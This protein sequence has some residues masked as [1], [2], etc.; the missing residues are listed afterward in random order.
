MM[1]DTNTL[2]TKIII[3]NKPQCTSF[4]QNKLNIKT[5][6]KNT[7]NV[8]FVGLALEGFGVQVDLKR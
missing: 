5:S 7:P 8:P 6:Q 1:C 3:V 4:M 2:L